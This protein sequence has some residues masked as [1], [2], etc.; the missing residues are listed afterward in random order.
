MH[1]NKLSST[2]YY[3]SDDKITGKY[4]IK[5]AVSMDHYCL[6]SSRL[7]FADPK[8]PLVSGH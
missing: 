7:Y 2:K 8:K 1:Y 5:D 4:A 3:W 6:L